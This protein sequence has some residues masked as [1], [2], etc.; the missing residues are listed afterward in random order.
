[1]KI[2]PAFIVFFIVDIISA[3]KL[4]EVFPTFTSR[5]FGFAFCLFF[6][7][8]LLIIWMKYLLRQPEAVQKEIVLLVAEEKGV[9]T[10][11]LYEIIHNS[12]TKMR[13]IHFFYGEAFFS[14]FVLILLIH[15]LGMSFVAGGSG[16]VFAEVRNAFSLSLLPYYLGFCSSAIMTIML[17]LMYNRKNDVIHSLRKEF[18][19]KILQAVFITFFYESGGPVLLF[20]ALVSFIRVFSR[21]TS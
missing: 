6:V 15:F 4:L 21:K 5:F 7:N 12:W 1:M 20:V 18:V 2:T 16:L 19:I 9:V 8:L 3:Y 11:S 17:A 13:R 10:R 14:I